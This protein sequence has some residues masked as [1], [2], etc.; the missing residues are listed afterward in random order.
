MFWSPFFQHF[1]VILR[2]GSS[3]VLGSL[4][5]TYE[6][7]GCRKGG[8]TRGVFLGMG[9]INMEIRRERFEERWP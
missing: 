2:E 8:L 7:K 1:N 9:L 6:G 4:T 3:L 5:W